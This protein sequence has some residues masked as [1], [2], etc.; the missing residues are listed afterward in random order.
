[1]F[2]EIYLLLTAPRFDY[3]TYNTMI[4]RVNT[5]FSSQENDPN[6]IF[7]RR[8]A[9]LMND[10][11]PRSEPL[12]LKTL[13]TVSSEKMLSVYNKLFPGA[14]NY[15]VMI[16]GNINPAQLKPL[17]CQYLASLPK[18]EKR[19]WKDDGLRYPAKAF[20][21]TFSQKMETPKTR[22]MVG[23]GMKA[24]YTAENMIYVSAIEHILGLRNTAE[25]REKEG[26]TYGVQ[27]RGFLSLRPIPFARMVM[28]FDT[29][30]QKAEPL[31]PKVADVF[32][33]LFSEIL[34]DD[35]LK[36]KQHFLKAHGED[37]RKNEYWLA[38]LAEYEESGID[39]HTD[40]EKLVNALSGDEEHLRGCEPDTPRDAGVR[41]IKDVF[42]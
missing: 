11:N 3:K 36:A 35:V 30:P 20:A 41:R 7:A 38:V 33:G 5:V 39:I 6:S 21:H 19:S 9:L 26:G 28:I 34:D 23:Y 40:Y 2:Q 25:I 16:V 24:K 14:R 42:L 13:E 10:D 1:M 32:E 4:D 37:I 12:S 8:L 29:D 17:V 31:I 22:V 15:T 27:E 18:G